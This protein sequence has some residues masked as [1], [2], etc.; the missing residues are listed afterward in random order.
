M[1]EIHLEDEILQ[2]EI[3][4]WIQISQPNAT[5]LKCRHL[6]RNGCVVHLLRRFH[7]M[8][9]FA[10]RFNLPSQTVFNT[11]KPG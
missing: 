2:G 11:G 1:I 8:E 5:E 10:T 7:Q 3:R 6:L 9:P 4:R